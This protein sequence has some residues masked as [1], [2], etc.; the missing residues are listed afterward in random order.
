V[1]TSGL[2]YNACR[3]TNAVS[4]AFNNGHRDT[5]I[6]TSA[7]L[8]D[9]LRHFGY[10]AEMMRIEAAAA[11]DAIDRAACILGSD[12]DG[13]RRQKANPGMWCGHVGVVTG[14]VLLDPTLD[15]VNDTYTYL[16]A[17]PMFV[18]FAAGQTVFFVPTGDNGAEVR[19]KLAVV[20]KAHPISDSKA[21][22]A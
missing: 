1:I 17:T 12:G 2:F 6:L 5:C 18:E 9:V 11:N 19:F 10:S 16:G 3:Y 15:Q 13:S 14:N 4:V 20:G 7:A 22:G 21:A 8:R